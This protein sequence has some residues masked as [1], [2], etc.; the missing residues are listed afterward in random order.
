ML[1]NGA[2]LLSRAR[3]PT[4]S[5]QGCCL[6]AEHADHVGERGRGVVGHTTG[7]RAASTAL[8]LGAAAAGSGFRR[9]AKAAGLLQLAAGAVRGGGGG[10]EGLHRGGLDPALKA[11]PG[12]PPHRAA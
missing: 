5:F 9:T 3:P 6:V 11:V 2:M 7:R 1:I 8:M 10:A 4:L 12:C